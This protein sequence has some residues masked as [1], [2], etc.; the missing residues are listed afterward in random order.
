MLIGGNDKLGLV[1]HFSLKAGA[2]CPG[3]T[4]T[5][6]DDC[7]AKKFLFQMPSVKKS[8][9]RSKRASMH[10]T[11]A[12]RMI[13]YIKLMRL[14][15]VRIHSSGDFYSWRYIK[16]WTRI[17]RS[18]PDT[19]FYAY[20]RSWRKVDSIT[21]AMR[22]ALKRLSTFPNMTLWLSCDKDTGKPPAWPGVPWAYMACD[23]DDIPDYIPTLVFRV[24]RSTVMR[25]QPETQAIVCPL[26]Q[27]VDLPNT[28]CETC[29]MCY[30]KS[31]KVLKKLF[32]VSE[33]GLSRR[34]NV[35]K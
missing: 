28:T 18:C 23:D 35:A 25:A 13:A 16:K 14:K 6:S 12:T 32:P 15:T 4:D 21:P 27:G 5:C 7:Y 33:I 11:F 2:T 30:N 17:I 9:T 1:H 31:S 22:M 3:Q 20:T 10:R 29:R 24:R 26:E 8:H 34:A 19:Q